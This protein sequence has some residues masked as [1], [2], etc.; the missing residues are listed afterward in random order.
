MDT[1]E[2]PEPPSLLQLSSPSTL[3]LSS[4]ERS[5]P[6]IILMPLAG[7]SPVHPCLSCTGGQALDA[8][9][10]EVAY[11]SSCDT[12]SRHKI[13]FSFSYGI[14]FLDH[15]QSFLCARP[16]IFLSAANPCRW[17]ASLFPTVQDVFMPPSPVKS[18]YHFQCARS[19]RTD[20]QKAEGQLGFIVVAADRSE[21]R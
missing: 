20:V 4:Q 21:S 3:S 2:I 8:A 5:T 14:F 18:C 17:N 11:S 6:F 12:L 7:L 19:Q 9:V 16:S 13:N 15:A 10:E 1:D